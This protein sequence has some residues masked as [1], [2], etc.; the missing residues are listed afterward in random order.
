[1]KLLLPLEQIELSDRAFPPSFHD[2]LLLGKTHV[3]DRLAS[4]I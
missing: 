1:M 4:D 3:N 2:R